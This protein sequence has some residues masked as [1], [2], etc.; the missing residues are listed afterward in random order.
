MSYQ[1]IDGAVGSPSYE[2]LDSFPSYDKAMDIFQENFLVT[3]SEN[4]G[5]VYDGPVTS[6]ADK[7]DISRRQ[8]NRFEQEYPLFENVLKRNYFQEKEKVSLDFFPNYSKISEMKESLDEML[9]QTHDDAAF[10]D[11]A[12]QLPVDDSLSAKAVYL[13]MQDITYKDAKQE[14]NKHYLTQAFLQYGEDREKF[15]EVTGRSYDTMW[16]KAKS[17]GIDAEKL[18][19]YKHAEASLEQEKEDQPKLEDS[20]DEELRRFMEEKIIREKMPEDERW[21]V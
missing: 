17:L 20:M 11:I 14:F 5:K 10:T 7:L 15:E 1:T 13:G 19:S 16:R 21:A 2:H 3:Q 4:M 8:L 9:P 12:K 18:E 6:L